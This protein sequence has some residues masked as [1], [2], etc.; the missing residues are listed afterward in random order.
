MNRKKQIATLLTLCLLVCIMVA[1]FCETVSAAEGE[2]PLKNRKKY[3][4]PTPLQM[5][6][7]VGS[8]LVMIAVVKY[9]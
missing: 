4:Q 2:D 1:W 3:E 7:G 5:G 9:L 8:F 6:I